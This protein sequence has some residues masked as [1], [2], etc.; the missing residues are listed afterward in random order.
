MQ[1]IWTIDNTASIGSHRV[2]V[3]GA[4][5]IGRG[6]VAQRAPED[7]AVNFD[8]VKDGLI[9]ECN[10]ISGLAAFTIEVLFFP[11][12]GGGHEQ[13]FVHMQERASENRALIELR[14]VDGDFYLDTYLHSTASQLTLITPEHLHPS[15]NWYWAALSYDGTTMR[16]FVN[17]VEEANGLVDFAPL[18][19]GLTS[20]GVRQ[21]QVSWF[22]GCVRQI[23]VSNESLNPSQLQTR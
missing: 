4:P 15:G 8:G 9:I 19:D 7:Q 22:K 13:R 2:D 14:S 18:Q 21:N 5:G 16:H 3:I 12:A 20:I 11:V 6:R 23:R 10:P 1:T 17:G